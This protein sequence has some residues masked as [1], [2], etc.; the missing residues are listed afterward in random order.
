VEFSPF[1]ERKKPT[2]DPKG[3]ESKA[4]QV[5]EAPTSVTE[6]P[7]SSKKKKEGKKGK[8]AEDTLDRPLAGS[9]GSFG[10]TQPRSSDDGLKPISDASSK[11]SPLVVPDNQEL[12]PVS[13]KRVLRR[14]TKSSR[15]VGTPAEPVDPG[16]SLPTSDDDKLGNPASSDVP[17]LS[18]EKPAPSLAGKP[19][20]KDNPLRGSIWLLAE[21]IRIYDRKFRALTSATASIKS[22][23]KRM[24][25]IITSGDRLF[26]RFISETYKVFTGLPEELWKEGHHEP[27]KWT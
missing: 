25:A 7:K 3:P 10:S 21:N 23:P 2:T 27:L 24:E 9:D 16:E 5:V 8:K 6:A 12:P 1:I 17:G 19:E 20:D 18:R 26:E 4:P 22:A 11:S 13:K 15:A 14:K